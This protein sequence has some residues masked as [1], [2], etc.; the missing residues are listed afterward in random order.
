[1]IVL[2]GYFFVLTALLLISPSTLSGQGYHIEV[3][4][5]GLSNDTLILG[6]YFT[7]RMVPKDTL[8]L[9]KQGHGVFK[10]SEVFEGGLYLIYFN[11]NYYFDLLLGDDQVLKVRTDTSDLAGSIEYEGSE[12][13][14]IFQD[15][16]NHL[17]QKRGELEKQQS[18]LALAA[19]NS[20]IS[21]L[22]FNLPGLRDART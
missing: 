2:R 3:T 6:E 5:T 22:T 10:G 7:S 1:M 12:D 18:L 17:Q 4:M 16:K 19:T 8:V 15:Y 20:V 11:P 14:R 21:A 13:N 9:D